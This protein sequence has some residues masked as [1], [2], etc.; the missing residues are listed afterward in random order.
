MNFRL[1]RRPR[2]E[3]RFVNA[4]QPAR[5]SPSG[6]RTKKRAARVL[7][8]ETLES[9]V[10]LDGMPV[11]NEFMAANATTLADEDG[12]FPDWIELYNRGDAAV[13][14]DGWYLT[15]NATDLTKW[16]LPAEVLDPGEYLVVFASNQNRATVGQ[17]LHTNFRLDADGELLALVMPD[18][19]TVASS[20]SPTFPPQV[21][22]ISF[23]TATDIATFPMV[24]ATADAK[25]F[26]PSSG[27][28][29]T[30]WTGLGFNDAAWQ[31][32]VTGIGY[33]ATPTPPFGDLVRTN[34][35]AQMYQQRTSAYVRVP[36]NLGSVPTI[37]TLKLRMKY[38]DAFVAY[39]NG[40]EIARS[41]VPAGGAPAWDAPA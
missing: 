34:L 33:A 27:A 38:D 25:V 2:P 28:L 39:L 32:G 41:N 3:L 19:Q 37:D 15:D 7:Q 9:R 17:P 5:R 36:F 20:F 4:S 16:R 1:F 10:V 12:A 13:N 23:G 35:Q 30:T 8:L 31:D 14:L 40:I 22:D 24:Q 6:R 26:V 18:G 21:D 29:G 11:I